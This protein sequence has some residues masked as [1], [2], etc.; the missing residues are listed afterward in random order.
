MTL[1]TSPGPVRDYPRDWRVRLRE[2]FVQTRYDRPWGWDG[3]VNYL[4]FT[5]LISH[6]L[7]NLLLIYICKLYWNLNTMF[8]CQVHFLLIY[9]WNFHVLS[10]LLLI[11]ICTLESQYDVRMSGNFLLIYIC[12][13][14]VLSYLLLIYMCKL[15][16]NLN[17]MFVYMSGNFLLIF[18]CNFHVLSNLLLIYVCTLHWNLNTMF[19]CQVIFLWFSYVISMS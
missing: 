1:L 4:W 8:V 7:S 11:Y 9:I 6:V 14:H 3:Q 15:H 17:T 19:V 13:F 10:H 16:W 2:S 12:N 18:M 5:Y